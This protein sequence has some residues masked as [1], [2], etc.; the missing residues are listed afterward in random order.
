MEKVSSIFTVANGLST[1]KVKKAALE[2]EK[3]LAIEQNLTRYK[4][5]QDNILVHASL[6]K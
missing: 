2:I 6:R 5:E 4:F 1:M 3:I